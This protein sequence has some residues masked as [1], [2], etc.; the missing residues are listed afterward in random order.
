MQVPAV[1]RGIASQFRQFL[2]TFTDEKGRSVYGSRIRVLGQ[3]NAESLEVSLVH[4]MEAKG[5][6]AWFVCFA[7]T[8]V[9]PI[10]DRVAMDCVELQYPDYAMI[11]AEIHVRLTDHASSTKLRDLRETNMGH[12]V[13]VSGVVTRRTG[14][15]PSS[16]LSTLTVSS[17]RRCWVRTLRSRTRSLSCPSA[18]TANLRARSRS[19]RKRRCIETSRK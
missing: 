8:E 7:P 16:S 12:L 4:L 17:A 9:L 2:L 5:I 10:F 11:H 19:T 14:V 6:L 18:T 15:F 13:K 3:D 1:D